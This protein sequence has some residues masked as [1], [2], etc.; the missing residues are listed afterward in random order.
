M[1]NNVK[2]V[3]KA[4]G[5]GFMFKVFIEF[6]VLVDSLEGITQSYVIIG[7]IS[8]VVSVV[9]Y[10]VIWNYIELVIKRYKEVKE[11]TK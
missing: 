10:M 4:L 2:V 3:F 7:F 11:A 9:L 6:V 8:G 5:L 1:I